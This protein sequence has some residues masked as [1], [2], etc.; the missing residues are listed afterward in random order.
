V[1]NAV[2]DFG[3]TAV[4][5]VLEVRTVGL[6]NMALIWRDNVGLLEDLFGD[7]IGV[8]LLPGSPP[9]ELNCICIDGLL[10]SR[11]RENNSNE[12][13]VALLGLCRLGRQVSGEADRTLSELNELSPAACICGTDGDHTPGE[14]HYCACFVVGG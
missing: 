14:Q 10:T 5:N 7:D 11:L 13:A 4:A 8:K 2:G 1:L 3:S 9:D 6:L 12:N